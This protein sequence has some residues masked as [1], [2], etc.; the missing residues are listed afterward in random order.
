MNTTLRPW[1]STVLGVI[2]SLV[3]AIPYSGNALGP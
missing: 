2:A 1:R 3:L